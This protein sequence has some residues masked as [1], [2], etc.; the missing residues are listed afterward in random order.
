LVHAG[1]NPA[2]RTKKK[3]PNVEGAEVGLRFRYPLN[4]RKSNLELRLESNQDR[5]VTKADG[6]PT[7]SVPE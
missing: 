6:Q 4:T 3:P 5:Y 2:T 1:S 7:I